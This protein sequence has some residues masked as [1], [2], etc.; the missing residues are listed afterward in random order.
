MS[1]MLTCKQFAEELTI[2]LNELA[3]T[4]ERK[5]K[6]LSDEMESLIIKRE[7][8][9]TIA[10]SKLPWKDMEKDDISM[11]LST[12]NLLKK[13]VSPPAV[14]LPPI[15]KLA[16]QHRCCLDIK[17]NLVPI[18][19][20][21]IINLTQHAEAGEYFAK[22]VMKQYVG[23][24]ERYGGDTLYFDTINRGKVAIRFP[25]FN[26]G[27]LERWREIN[28]QCHSCILII[29]PIVAKCQLYK[30]L[31]KISNMLPN[32]YEG[33]QVIVSYFHGRIDPLDRTGYVRI[34]IPENYHQFDRSTPHK[35]HRA[36]KNGLKNLPLWYKRAAPTVRRCN[37][38]QY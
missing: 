35:V 3:R 9:R 21:P 22:E 13:E 38:F 36:F 12:L 29:D 26:Y 5:K 28:T 32:V 25:V 15:T 24:T 30:Y 19:Y 27:S 7:F 1:D 11:S 16:E 4:R 8:K 20:L 33:L 17:Q 34:Y 14:K 37:G 2:R 6:K 10:K 23:F 18:F 31:I